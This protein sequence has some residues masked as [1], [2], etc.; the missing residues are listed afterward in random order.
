LEKHPEIADLVDR[1]QRT[2]H[3]LWL[4]EDGWTSIEVFSP[5]YEIICA[6]MALHGFGFAKTETEWRI[7]ICEEDHS[8]STEPNDLASWPKQVN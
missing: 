6:M 1:L 3:E 8:K 2:L 5:I 7:V 4:S